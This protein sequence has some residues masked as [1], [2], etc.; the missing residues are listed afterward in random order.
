MFLAPRDG[1]RLL[2]ISTGQ[3]RLYR[4]GWTAA[5]VPAAL[6]GGTTIDAEARTAIADLIAALSDAG[7]LPG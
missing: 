1:M 6:S 7:I 4:G 5:T 3:L 2:D